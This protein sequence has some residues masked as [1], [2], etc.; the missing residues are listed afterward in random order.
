VRII[1]FREK[2]NIGFGN[3]RSTH[4]ESIPDAEDSILKFLFDLISKRSS[5]STESTFPVNFSINWQSDSLGAWALEQ[6][7]FQ[8]AWN[9]APLFEFEWVDNWDTVHEK[10]YLV[11]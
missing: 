4:V 5:N 6:E 11:E 3:D 9:Y 8:N 2:R 10:G 1:T 7:N